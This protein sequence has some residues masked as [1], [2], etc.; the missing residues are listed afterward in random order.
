MGHNRAGDNRRKKLRRHKKEVTKK[1]RKA[2][3]RREP[4]NMVEMPSKPKF[5]W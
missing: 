3:E 4:S 5:D 2:A 1:L